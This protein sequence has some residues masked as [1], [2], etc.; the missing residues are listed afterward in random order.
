MKFSL[1]VFLLVSTSL[2]AV[3]S[4]SPIRQYVIRRDFF[5]NFKAGEFAVYDT[6]EKHL[7]YRIESKYFP[8]QNIELIAYPS[9][10]TVGKLQAKL[11]LLLYKGDFSF[12]DPL[13]NQWINGI[14]E[15]KFN[16]ARDVFTITWN[17]RQ[18]TVQKDLGSLTN[19]FYDGNTLL[20]QF[21]LRP[22]S[23]L[24]ARKYDMQIFSDKYPENIYLLALAARD[25]ISS[26]KKFKL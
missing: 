24:W 2:L 14:I 10:R 1:V 9:K 11:N 13:S 5:S 8:L 20:A 4:S 16:L 7:Y 6:N 3:K 15:Q 18:I 21:R 22:A 23:I 17:E 26:S 25:H 19:H 12:Q